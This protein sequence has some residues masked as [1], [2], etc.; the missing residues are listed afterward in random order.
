MMGYQT[1]CTRV[2]LKPDSVDRVREWARTLNET[3][4]DE[5]IATLRDETVVLEAVFLDRSAEG[6]F[7]IYIMKAESFEQAQQAV[8]TS[9]HDI[10][11]YHQEF[12]RSAYE[13][14]KPLELLVDLDR[15][16][17]LRV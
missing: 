16:E 10:D 3:R 8:A 13:S 14:W 12:K 1:R 2:K 4:R 6:D 17:E 15:I 9:T 5:A 11:K 7:L